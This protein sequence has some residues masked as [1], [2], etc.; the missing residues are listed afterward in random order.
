MEYLTTYDDICGLAAIPD[1]DLAV[2][3]ERAMLLANE[4]YENVKVW[5]LH[6]TVQTTKAHAFV[7]AKD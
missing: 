3:T 6:G 2:S 1:D 7:K 5:T 4:G